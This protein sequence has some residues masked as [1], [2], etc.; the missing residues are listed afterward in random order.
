MAIETKQ[1]NIDNYILIGRCDC[2]SVVK[3]PFYWCEEIIDEAEKV[4]INVIDLKRENFSEEKVTKHIN[5]KKPRLILLNGHGDEICAMGYNQ[6]PVI[7]LNKNDY[8][9]KDKIAHII[10]CKTALLLGQFAIDKGCKGYLGY[11]GLFHIKNIHPEPDKDKVSKMFKEAVNIASKTLLAG[12]GIK[13]AF[14]NSQEVYEKHISACKKIYFDIS[15]SDT[16]RDFMQG[17][18]GAL[19][20]NKKNQVFIC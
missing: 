20:E 1:N 6:T 11:E 15:F 14:I 8:L 9:L 18:I 13:E 5:D 2:D 16:E 3:F 4:G 12:K 10:S 7:T 19:E 17:V